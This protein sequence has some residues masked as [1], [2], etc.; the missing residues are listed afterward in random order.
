MKVENFAL[1]FLNYKNTQDL[2]G[3]FSIDVK[4]SVSFQFMW[5]NA[6]GTFVAQYSNIE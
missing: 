1:C 2:F 4:C 5:P 6:D 3:F